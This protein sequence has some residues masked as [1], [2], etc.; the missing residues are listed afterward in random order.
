MHEGQVFG[1]VDVDVGQCPGG[2]SGGLIGVQHARGGQQRP[3][4]GQE[5]DLEQ[6]GGTVTDPGHEP[7][8]DAHPG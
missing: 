5:R 7:G 3:H 6:G 1:A 8:G 4:V 2:A